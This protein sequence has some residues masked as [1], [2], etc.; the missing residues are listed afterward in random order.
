MDNNYQ[1][2]QTKKSKKPLLAGFLLILQAVSE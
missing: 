1:T 2:V